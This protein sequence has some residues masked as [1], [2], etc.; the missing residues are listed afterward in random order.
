[1][2]AE[3]ITSLDDLEALRGDWTALCDRSPRVTP[4]Q[5]PEWLI[6][7]WHAFQPGEPWVLAVRKEERLAALAPLLI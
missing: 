6:P 2:P 3:E 1:M 7:W 4:F 5:R